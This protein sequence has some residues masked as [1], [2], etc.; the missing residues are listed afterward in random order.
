M[1]ELFEGHDD[2][3]GYELLHCCRKVKPRGVIGATH[4]KH[5]EGDC[6]SRV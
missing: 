1:K 2:E 6:P 5:V 3:K 4:A